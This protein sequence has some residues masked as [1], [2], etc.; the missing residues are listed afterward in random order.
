M[1]P[2]RTPPTTGAAVVLGAA[3]V[4]LALSLRSAI[5]SLGVLLPTV[6]EA[7]DFA[8]AGV[9][10]LTTLPPLCFA[11]IGLGTGRLV[12]R[13]G[14]HRVAVGLLAAV[15]TGLVARALTDSFALFLLATVVIMAG[16]AIGNVVL[17]PLAKQHFPHRVALISSLYGAAVVGGGSLASALTVPIG[18]ATG[19]WRIAL[20]GWAVVAF[21]GMAMWLPTAF[22]DERPVED[23]RPKSHRITLGDVARTRLGLAFL[24]CFGVQSSQ[25]Y[26]QFG[27]WGEILADAGADD[28]HAGAL[29]GVI[30][31]IG[32]PVTLGLPALIRVTRGGMTLPIMFACCT[33]AGWV[34]VIVAPLAVGGWLW[35]V[36]LGM[37]GGAFTWVLAMI[38]SR[39]RTAEGTSQ[40][41]A[42]TQGVGYL[43]A[44]GTTFG[45]GLLHELTGSWTA[46]LAGTAVLAVGIGLAGAVIA[47]SGP[48]EEHLPDRIRA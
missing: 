24:T 37:G 13:F 18:D 16:A 5:G 43:V 39:S 44:A 3:I 19:S 42:L 35:A 10:V 8:P 20:G 38:A 4:V 34:G 32:I 31:G 29:L 47:R 40:L 22:R 26:V 23:T 11:V 6:R 15:A 30:T 9:S 21:I 27:W 17:P 41:S 33:V 45:V 48:L 1:P 46:P 25:A 28:A 14:V 2:R 7:L 12:L 36:L